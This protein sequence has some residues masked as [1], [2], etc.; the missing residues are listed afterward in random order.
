M[1]RMR[2]V[3]LV[4]LSVLLLMIGTGAAALAGKES[5]KELRIEEAFDGKEGAMVL[6]NLKNDKVYVFNK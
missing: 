2:R 3:V 1:E 5:T 4:F 6:K